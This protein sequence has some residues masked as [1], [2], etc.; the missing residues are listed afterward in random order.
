MARA[1]ECVRGA[2]ARVVRRERTDS[3][4]LFITSAKEYNGRRIDYCFIDGASMK[5]V[6]PTL[7]YT[8]KAI[9]TTAAHPRPRADF[10]RPAGG[11]ACKFNCAGAARRE[12]PSR[13]RRMNYHPESVALESFIARRR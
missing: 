11:C 13:T 2:A 5:R 12:L 3:G 4:G 1:R 9:L 10:A 7:N 8:S 6:S